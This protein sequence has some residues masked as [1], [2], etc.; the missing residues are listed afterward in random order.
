MTGSHWRSL[1]GRDVYGFVQR[2]KAGRETQ[3]LVNE[4]SASSSVNSGAFAFLSGRCV[5]LFCVTCSRLEVNHPS[6]VF[7]WNAQPSDAT[8]AC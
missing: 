4:D 3:S 7:N 5:S 1:I 8:C 2:A 6:V